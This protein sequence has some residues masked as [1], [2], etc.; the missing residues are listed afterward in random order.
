MSWTRGLSRVLFK[1]DM[2]DDED[3]DTAGSDFNSDY[4]NTGQGDISMDPECTESEPVFGSPEV[5]MAHRHTMTHNNNSS[6]HD[7]HY[8]GPSSPFKLLNESNRHAEICSSPT[9]LRDRVNDLHILSQTS[10]QTPNIRRKPFNRRLSARTPMRGILLNTVVKSGTVKRGVKRN[11]TP[12]EVNVNP[13]SPNI[14]QYHRDVKK[15]KP[16]PLNGYVVS[17]LF[18]MK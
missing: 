12:R 11:L 14:I 1:N 17:C 16:S 15:H 3:V 10:P 18:V 8:D 13:F 4:P 6:S 9:H 7:N 5:R 2:T